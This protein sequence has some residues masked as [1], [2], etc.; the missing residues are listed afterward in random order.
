MLVAVIL[1]T[2]YFEWLLMSQLVLPVYY[3]DVTGASWLLKSIEHRK[4]VQI[5][6]KDNIKAPHCWHF[7]RGIHRWP[8][9][10]GSVMRKV[11]RM[12]W[13]HYGKCKKKMCQNLLVTPSDDWHWLQKMLFENIYFFIYIYISFTECCSSITYLHL[14][15]GPVPNSL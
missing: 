7:V 12:P 6:S 8:S 13:R 1:S 10:K 9:H 4:C 2:Q 11:Y 3:S 15:N 14:N 5:N